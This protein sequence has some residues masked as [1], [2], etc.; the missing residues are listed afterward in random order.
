M[1]YKQFPHA[2]TSSA[3]KYLFKKC[4]LV[5]EMI[6][7][8]FH[9]DFC[10]PGFYNRNVMMCILLPEMEVKPFFSQRF[11]IDIFKNPCNLGDL[12]FAL[13]QKK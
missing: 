6:T 2:V 4:Y 9:V 7:F 12:C 5:A 3:L 11:Y 1:E 10:D 13:R 8:V